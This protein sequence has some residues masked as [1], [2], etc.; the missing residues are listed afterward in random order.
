LIRNPSLWKS[1]KVFV[2]GG[3]AL[4]AYFVRLES[5]R[6]SPKE[7]RYPIIVDINVC[8]LVRQDYANLFRYRRNLARMISL[9]YKMEHAAELVAMC[10]LGPTEF[11]KYP[12]SCSI[13]WDETIVDAAKSLIDNGKGSSYD[14]TIIEAVGAERAW[15]NEFAEEFDGLLHFT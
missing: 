10:V 7:K 8:R 11:A 2:T 12:S 9:E 3:K 1:F 4:N 13:T 6:L 5:Y 15:S 14:L